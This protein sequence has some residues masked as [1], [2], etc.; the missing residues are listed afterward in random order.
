MP[1]K[2]HLSRTNNIYLP[3][4]YLPNSYLP[5]IALL[6]GLIGSLLFPATAS[7]IPAFARQYN[8]T[9]TT[10]HAA[11]PKLNRFGQDFIKSNYRLPN[12]KET[13][14]DAGD[15]PMIAPPWM[16]VLW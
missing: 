15:A 9:C 14:L 1:T 5:S 8:L 10:C 6:M 4:I 7:A 3:N 2:R 16:C 11:F 12:W 13:T